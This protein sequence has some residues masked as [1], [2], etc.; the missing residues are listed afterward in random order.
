MEI[1][2]TLKTHPKQEHARLEAQNYL[3]ELHLLLRTGNTMRQEAKLSR[4]LVQAKAH[5]EIS[6]L[7]FPNRSSRQTR[8]TNDKQIEGDG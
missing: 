8:T 3:D 1:P 2:L 7:D 4:R 5:A 6:K